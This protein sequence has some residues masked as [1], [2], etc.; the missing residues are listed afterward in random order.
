MFEPE[1]DARSPERRALDEQI[2]AEA[3]A[4]F[5]EHGMPEDPPDTPTFTFEEYLRAMRNSVEVAGVVEDGEIRLCHPDTRLPERARVLI[6]PAN[7]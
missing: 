7:D 6:L 1:P 3:E 2:A 4:A 5:A